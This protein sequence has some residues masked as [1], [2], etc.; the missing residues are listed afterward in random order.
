VTDD[1]GIREAVGMLEALRDQLSAA[2][3]TAYWD[4]P[5]GTVKAIVRRDGLLLFVNGQPIEADA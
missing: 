4:T 2:A 5:H 1:V 3:L